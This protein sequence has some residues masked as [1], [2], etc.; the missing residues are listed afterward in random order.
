[1]NNPNKKAKYS[2]KSITSFFLPTSKETASTVAFTDTGFRISA[3]AVVLNL[4]HPLL[5]RNPVGRPRKEKTQTTLVPI[6]NFDIQI[7]DISESVED[8]TII[9]R[10]F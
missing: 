8:P 3:N 6:T 5:E 4:V 2:S 7:A 1:M 10:I 9:G